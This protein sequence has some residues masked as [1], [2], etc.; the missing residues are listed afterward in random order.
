MFL[1]LSKLYLI[2][3]L[4]SNHLFESWLIIFINIVRL[5][6][7]VQSG[8]KLFRTLVIIT[9]VLIAIELRQTSEFKKTFIALYL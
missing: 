8:I 3:A 2:W 1:E 4:G 7:Y 6:K 5:S 9:D